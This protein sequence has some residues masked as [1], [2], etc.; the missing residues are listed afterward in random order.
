MNCTP[1]KRAIPQL[2]IHV[3]T[4]CWNEATLL[5]HF[6]R[7]YAF[8][9][10]IVVFDNGSTDGSLDLIAA[11]PR[12]VLRHFDS[13]GKIHEAAYLR[14]KNNAWKESRGQADWVIVCDMDELLFDP[15]LP[16]L[17]GRMREA[18]GTVLKPHGY[19]MIGER[20]PTPNEDLL[21][22]IPLG[23]RSYHFDKCV[24][25]DPQAIDEINY[26]VGAHMCEPQGRVKLFR[27]PH[28]ALLH[29]KHLGFDYVRKRYEAVASRLSEYNLEREFGR[30]YVES[31]QRTAQRFEHW[32]SIARRVVP[33][34]IN[35]LPPEWDEPTDLNEEKSRAI[36]LLQ[37]SDCPAAQT[38]F[39]KI[40]AYRPDDTESLA[41]LATTLRRQ[42]RE[43]EA[44]FCLLQALGLSPDHPDIWINLANLEFSQN[45]LQNAANF[46][47]NALKLQPEHSLAR[48]RLSE[49]DRVINT[50][51]PLV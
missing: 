13:G 39:E 46:Y 24:L 44:K 34:Q 40:L 33:E 4:L 48:E 49:V 50:Q 35:P 25:F 1:A 17:L 2:R 6:F 28:T 10:R 21:G 3:Y 19:E 47:R 22:L 42:N 30:Q 18:G 37:A 5:P 14:L 15:H 43:D 27:R 26:G 12:A 16:E 11:E 38:A 41:N 7:H 23:V 45:Q 29:Y 9:E 31:P 51:Q 8:A 20:P 36:A 32:R